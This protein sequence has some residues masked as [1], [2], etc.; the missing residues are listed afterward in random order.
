MT[1]IENNAAFETVVFA[2]S[3]QEQP[4]PQMVVAVN[5]FFRA[6]DPR[7]ALKSLE[8]AVDCRRIAAQR[9]LVGLIKDLTKEELTRAENAL[10]SIAGTFVSVRMVGSDWRAYVARDGRTANKVIGEQTAKKFKTGVMFLWLNNTVFRSSIC[11]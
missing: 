9:L 2:K 10:N 5:A 6:I 8:S 7:E 3:S 11:L 4:S 1:E